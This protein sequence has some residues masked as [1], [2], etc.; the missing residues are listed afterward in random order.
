VV[1]RPPP[2]GGEELPTALRRE[3]LPAD[4][5]EVRVVSLDVKGGDPLASFDCGLPDGRRPET[6]GHQPL[7]EL[8]L[9]RPPAVDQRMP[10]SR[11]SAAENQIVKRP[12]QLRIHAPILVPLRCRRC[13]ETAR[14]LSMI[15]VSSLVI[16]FSLAFWVGGTLLV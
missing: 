11:D 13:R 4:V 10:S 14:L 1:V 3:D 16:R 15:A 7:L 9:D 8:G 12:G 2:L 6:V 5:P